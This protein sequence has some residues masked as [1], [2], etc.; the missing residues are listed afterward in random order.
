MGS[1]RVGRDWVTCILLYSW[2][3]LVAQTVKNPP[4]MCETWVR[5]WIGEI[6]LKWQPTPLFLPG[7]SHGQR[8]LV[9]HSP[10]GQKELDVTEQVSTARCIYVKLH[11][12]AHPTLPFLLCAHLSI[13]YACVSLPALD[14]G[15]RGRGHMYPCNW[16]TLLCSR[17]FH[18]I[19][20]Q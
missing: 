5:P 18:N 12:P 17:N 10:W 2:A 16:F 3:F 4:A 9:G 1:P 19:M 20:K 14:V 7:K 8:S 15:A 11:L 6:T 13:P